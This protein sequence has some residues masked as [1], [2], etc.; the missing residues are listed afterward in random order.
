V[1]GR[2]WRGSDVHMAPTMVG[3]D[4]HEVEEGGGTPGA[5]MPSCRRSVKGREEGELHQRLSRWAVRACV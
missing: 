2:G 1:E 5:E 3:A 4:R